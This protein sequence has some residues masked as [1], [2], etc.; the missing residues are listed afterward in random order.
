M[1]YE[2]ESDGVMIDS[3]E[4]ASSTF[5]HQNRHSHLLDETH[6]QKAPNTTTTQGI[7]PPSKHNNEIHDQ[8]TLNTT[9]T[10]QGIPPPPKQN[11][12]TQHREVPPQRINETQHR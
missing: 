1:S 11:N 12:E 6:G 3:P 9:T 7:P 8:K 4:P 5:H 10:T 2:N